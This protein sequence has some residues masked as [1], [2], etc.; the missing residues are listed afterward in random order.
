MKTRLCCLLLIVTAT[1]PFAAAEIPLAKRLPAST[2]FYAGWSGSSLSFEGSYLGQMLEAPTFERAADA[3]LKALRR[4]LNE[5][6]RPVADAGRK[7]LELAARRPAALA[8]IAFDPQARPPFPSVALLVNIGADRK[9]FDAERAKLVAALPDGIEIA[10]AR[11]DG[12]A[13]KRIGLGRR[14]EWPLAWGYLDKET[15][16]VTFGRDAAAVL[17]TVS[18]EKSLARREDFAKRL[19]ELAKEPQAALWIDVP[20]WVRRG[21][22]MMPSDSPSLK[23]VLGVFGFGEVSAIAG[24]VSVVD[25]GLLSRLRVTSPAPHRGLLAPLSGAPLSDADLAMV[26]ADADFLFA[27][28]LSLSALLDEVRRGAKRI[29]AAPVAAESPK[30]HAAK[31]LDAALTELDEALGLSVEKDLLASLGQTWV[32]YSA[33]SLGGSLT[34]TVATVDVKDPDA[35]TAGLAKLA[36]AVRGM[37]DEGPRRGARRRVR[38]LSRKVG[39]AEIRYFRIVDREPLPIAPAWCLH[40][41]RLYL[42]AWPQ[43]IEAALSGE[44]KPLVKT[45]AYAA[46]RKRLSDKA[47]TLTYVNMPG[48]LGR[49]YPLL[50]VGGTMLSGQIA[51]ETGVEDFPALPIAMSTLRKYVTAEASAVSADSE[52]VTFEAYGAVPAVGTV[53]PVLSIAAPLALP[54]LGRA[55]AEARAEVSSARLR[56]IGQGLMVH[57][58]QWRTYPAS[59]D[60]LVEKKALHAGALSHPAGDGKTVDYAYVNLPTGAP[61]NLVWAYEELRFARRGRLNVL[62]HDGSV[63]RLPLDRF[64]AE[65]ERTQQWLSKQ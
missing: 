26:P 21:E 15:F 57:Q 50:L 4:E 30:P 40:D 59:L 23:D 32:L 16:F 14:G 34:G 8:V 12:V 58:A 44:S 9:A 53:G 55:R 10:D 35:L 18:E 29:D 36:Q 62:Y 28:N 17:A 49:A 65:L 56:M 5:A 3:L 2:M 46:L 22:Q 7:M 61:G 11:T 63:R 60:V 41:G 13:Y 54:A 39:K 37:F 1:A 43:V 42:A 27:G 33:P 38:V 64:R 6:R 47:S 24:T 31:S 25:R 48:L 19:G 45:D 52:G 51:R 20:Q